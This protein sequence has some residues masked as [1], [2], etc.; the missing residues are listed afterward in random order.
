MVLMVSL[1]VMNLSLN[2][3]LAVDQFPAE[4]DE[5]KPAYPQGLKLHLPKLSTFSFWTRNVAISSFQQ[6]H[7]SAP[8]VRE[9]A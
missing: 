2:L 5:S 8:L 4:N 7:L 1:G 3:R 6:G 9:A